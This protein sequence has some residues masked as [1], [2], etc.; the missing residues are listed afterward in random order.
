MKRNIS[1]K[2]IEK[3]PPK[4]S[5]FK[6]RESQKQFQTVPRDIDHRNKKHHKNDTRPLER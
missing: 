5:K 4:C 1:R 2:T 3:I 6:N